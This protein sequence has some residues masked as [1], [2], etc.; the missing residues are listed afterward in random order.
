MLQLSVLSYLLNEQK[1]CY[2]ID[3]HHPFLI[4]TNSLLPYQSHA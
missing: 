3:S 1:F 4:D 2:S